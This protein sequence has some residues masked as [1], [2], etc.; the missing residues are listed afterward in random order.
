MIARGGSSITDTSSL[1]KVEL[2]GTDT[3]TYLGVG[4]TNDGQNE[5]TG[6]YYICD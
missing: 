6:H 1:A 4:N 3:W 2:P 5:S